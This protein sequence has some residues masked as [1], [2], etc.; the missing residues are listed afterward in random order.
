M[1]H[2]VMCYTALHAAPCLW[3][4][5]KQDDDVLNKLSVF[6]KQG[7]VYPYLTPAYIPPQGAG[8]SG[9]QGISFRTGSD[10][11]VAA[12]DPRS[13]LAN[14]K[15]W[16]KQQ[17]GATTRGGVANGN[18]AAAGREAELVLRAAEGL[19]SLRVTA[20]PSITTAAPRFVAKAGDQAA[21]EHGKQGQGGGRGQGSR[22]GRGGGASAGGG[23]ALSSR[24]QYDFMQDF[25]DFGQQVG[26]WDSS[27]VYSLVTSAVLKLL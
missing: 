19:H 27:A 26:A 6:N 14:S 4:L 18:G 23:S 8:S 5:A 25:D 9:S 11:L 3:Q 2:S 7:N 21:P 13:A 10:A 20:N 12:Y 22:S 24:L 17:Q 15:M 1:M 16:D